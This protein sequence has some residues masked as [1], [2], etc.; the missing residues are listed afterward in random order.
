MS[1]I[2][3]AVLTT[4]AVLFSSAV[5][6][7]QTNGV[8][9]DLSLGE[10]TGGELQIGQT[11]FKDDIGDWRLRCI[12]TEQEE[13]PC[14]LYQLLNDDAG[15]S[16]AEISIFRLE[17]EGE[18]VAGATIITPLETLLTA[19]IS[20]AV[21]GAN[22]RRYPFSFCNQIGCF[23]R[24]GLRQAD[25]EAFKRGAEATVTMVPVGAPDTPVALP[26]SLTGFTAGFD[27]ITLAPR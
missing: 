22:S 27:V 10:D 17:G 11:Y 18:A 25:V 14:Q 26:V 16:V 4:G 15:N 21:D 7:Q 13:D 20:L 5:F 9:S 24:L 1:H 6:A 19:Q 12:K 2:F 8:S 23:A 3:K